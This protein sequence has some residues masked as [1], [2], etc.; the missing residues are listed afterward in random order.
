M[1]AAT[2]ARARRWAPNRSTSAVGPGELA[3]PAIRGVGGGVIYF[4]DGKS[5]LAKVWEIEFEPVD[6]A[7]GRMPG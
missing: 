4:I 1:R 2:V 5:E 3:I 7:G 6:D